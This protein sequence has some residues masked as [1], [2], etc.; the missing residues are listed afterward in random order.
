[1]ISVERLLRVSRGEEN[2]NS[3]IDRPIDHL[4]ACH[5]RIEDRLGSL[6][7]AGA[8]LESKR[9]EALDAIDAAFRYFESS[10]V[11]HT[12]DEEESVF[13]R[14]WAKMSAEER[15]EI[16]MLEKQHR[17]AD[18]IYAELKV[19]ATRLRE[20][21]AEDPKLAAHFRWLVQRFAALYRHHI[22]FENRELVRIAR[23]DLT[24]EELGAISEEMRRRRAR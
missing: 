12:A 19:A 9:A 21:P 1:M 14:L 18:A 2:P 23:R 15:A 10:G 16:K 17:D 20:Q 7:R 11:M 13:P 5:G 3:T 6:E 8:H 24:P 22:E 4:V